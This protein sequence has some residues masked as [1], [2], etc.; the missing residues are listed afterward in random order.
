M[1]LSQILLVLRLRWWVVLGVFCLSLAGAYVVSKMMP[2]QYSAQTSILLDVKVDPLVA[3]LMP[4]LASTSY[5]ATQT[6]ILRSDRVAS[7]VVSMLKLA[8]NADAV[9][10]WQKESEGRVPIETFYGNMLKRGLLVETGGGSAVL[11]ISFTGNEPK[12][13]AAVTNAFAQSFIDLGVELRVGPAREY[14][15]FFDERLRQ[16]R[17]DLE[18]AQTRLSGFQQRRGIVVTNERMDQE[19]ARMNALESALASALA[20]SADTSSRQR[21]AGTETSIDVQ[22]SG[23]VQGLK[24]ELARAE[25]QLSEVSAKYGSNHPQRIELEARIVELKQQLAAE[26]RRVSGATAS[27]NRIAGQKINELR[28]MVDAQ[29]RTVLGLR[30]QRDEAGVLLRDVETAQRAYDAVAQR[31]AQ[32]ANESQAEQAAARV[33]SPAVEPLSHSKPNIPKNMVAAAILGLLLGVG[34]AFFAE[35]VDRR[36]RSEHDLSSMQD[37]PLL[38]VMA[39]SRRRATRLPNFSKPRGVPPSPPQL[40]LDGGLS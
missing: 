13:V 9:A 39:T 6:E 34:I 7:R 38:G 20:D 32:L 8:Q 22:Q 30:A 24:S 16:L 33:L 35:Y 37:V 19:M 5:M 15:Q 31:R 27:V 21:N 11:N 18:A 17:D 26:M 29:K 2:K 14:A 25:T 40:T 4:G 10:A 36:V 23:V 28:A 3:S 1:N 12:F